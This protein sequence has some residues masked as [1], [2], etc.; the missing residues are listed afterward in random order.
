[1]RIGRSAALAAAIGLAAAC[2]DDTLRNRVTVD[3]T[4]NQTFSPRTVTLEVGGQVTWEFHALGHNVTFDPAAAGRPADIPGVNL[5]VAIGRTFDTAGPFSYHCSIHP[6][7]TGE[8]IVQQA[9]EAGVG[10]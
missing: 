2:G 9:S 5:E 7:M 3:A 6:S 4:E 10:Y 1:M 8:V